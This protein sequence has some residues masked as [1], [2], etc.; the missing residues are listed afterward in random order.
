MYKNKR[1]SETAT[2][3]DTTQNY[4]LVDKKCTDVSIAVA[5]KLDAKAAMVRF[6]SREYKLHVG[7]NALAD[8]TSLRKRSVCRA[9]TL[10]GR[11]IEQNKRS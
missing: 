6:S 2:T 8:S 1:L 7:E 4:D 11:Y 9:V 3:H 10:E 5:Q